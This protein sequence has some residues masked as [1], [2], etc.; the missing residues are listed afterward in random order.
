MLQKLR[1]TIRE[2]RDMARE[3]ENSSDLAS[4]FFLRTLIYDTREMLMQLQN[5]CDARLVEMLKEDFD[6]EPQKLDG[7][8]EVRL[9]SGKETVVSA[10]SEKIVSELI[11]YVLITDDGENYK[12]N[13]PGIAAQLVANTILENSSVRWSTKKLRDIGFD[14]KDRGLAKSKLKKVRPHVIIE[15]DDLLESDFLDDVS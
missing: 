14:L 5:S 8:G 6:G 10:D 2:S 4:L 13:D 11:D 9:T 15:C 7:V 1:D 3:L 12:T